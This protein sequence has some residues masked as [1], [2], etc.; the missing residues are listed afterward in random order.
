ML[1]TNQATVVG[2]DIQVGIKHEYFKDILQQSLWYNDM[3]SVNS[4]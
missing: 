2:E 3:S 1:I 4:L